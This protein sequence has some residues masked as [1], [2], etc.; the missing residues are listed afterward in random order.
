MRTDGG[1]VL[2]LNRRELLK[3]GAAGAAG[4]M[5]PG[6]AADLDGPPDFTA[7]FLADTHVHSLR[8]A[9][10]GLKAAVEHAMTRP[11]PPEL[12]LTGGDLVMDILDEGRTSADEQFDLFDAAFEGVGVP[13][14]HCLGNHD[15]LGVYLTSGVP[16]KNPLWG[17]EYFLQ[18]FGRQ[19]TYTSFDH[20]GWHFVLLDSVAIRGRD[21]VG[22]VDADQLAWLRR[23]L[24]STDKPTVVAMH[25]PLLSNAW[26]WEHGT[27]APDPKKAIVANCNDVIR[28]LHKG[29]VKL[30][31]GGHL[32]IN[33][34]WAFKGV[35]YANVG[36][37]SGAWW[38]GPRDGFEEG[39]AL[40]EFRGDR[41]SW[42]YEDYGWDADEA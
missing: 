9:P 33:E 32:H 3:L 21:Y 11:T 24:A 37:V 26:E 12:L 41:V 8:R 18:R 23:D 16:R 13:V 19:R 30:V 35:E 29:P 39:Y 20:R 22:W 40:L 7:A 34:S 36:A 27:A 28:A 15:C 5:L 31:L 14:H 17:K 42:R 10:A 38:R 2:S 4:L 6:S 1:T 25:I